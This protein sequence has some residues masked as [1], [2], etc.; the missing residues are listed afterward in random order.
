MIPYALVLQ[1]L[2]PT[3]SIHLFI[4]LIP[5]AANSE[6][7][8]QIQETECVVG[9]PLF[10]IACPPIIDNTTGL[11]RCWVFLQNQD[12]WYLHFYLCNL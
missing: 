6:I 7:L 4:S 1:I 8:I 3:L 5:S 9:A 11:A 2:L 12:T 10:Y